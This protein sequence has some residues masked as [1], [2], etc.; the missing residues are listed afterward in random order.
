MTEIT[1]TRNG[2]RVRVSM[3][4]H[5]LVNPGN[6]PVCAALSALAYTMIR[7][8]EKKEE[9]GKI[10]DLVIDI[11]DGHVVVSF[12]DTKKVWAGGW[13]VLSTGFELIADSYSDN[14]RLRER[15]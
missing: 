11:D 13:E 9:D 3:H 8:L 6:D 15:T 7:W 10:K 1:Q 5:A 14:V 2:S 12:S 4:G